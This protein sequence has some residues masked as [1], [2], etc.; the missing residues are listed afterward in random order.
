M[1]GMSDSSSMS[2]QVKH[3]ITP[4]DRLTEGDQREFAAAV[5]RLHSADAWTR[6]RLDRT[7]QIDRRSPRP[8]RSRLI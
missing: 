5:L 7:R 1:T 3:L 4:F 6:R 2:D 8:S